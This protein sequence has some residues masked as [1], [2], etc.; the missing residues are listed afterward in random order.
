VAGVDRTEKDDL[1]VLLPLVLPRQIGGPF[2]GCFALISYEK[3]LEGF[4][5]SIQI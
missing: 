4:N 2:I 5:C 1:S 3:D